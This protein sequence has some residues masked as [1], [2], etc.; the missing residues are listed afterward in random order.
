MTLFNLSYFSLLQIFCPCRF[1]HNT[2]QALS[3]WKRQ[4][5]ALFAGAATGLAL[6]PVNFFPICFLTFPILTWLLDGIYVQRITKRRQRYKAAILTGWNFGFGYFVAGLWWLGGAVLIDITVYGWIMPFAVF[7]LPAYLAFFYAFATFV[8]FLLW[9]PGYRRIITLSIAFGLAEWLRSQIFTGFPWNALGYTAMPFPLLIQA[10]AV[11]GLDGMNMLAVLVYTTP[12]LF[13]ER[14]GK[15]IGFLVAAILM[16]ADFSFGFYR[17]NMEAPVHILASK[18]IRV[19]II[20]PSILQSEKIDIAT[21]RV[22][23]ERHLQLTA[24]APINGVTPPRLIIWPETSVPYILDYTPAALERITR[25]LKDN[26]LALVG[27]VRVEKINSATATFRYFNSLQIIHP[28]GKIIASADKVHLVPFGEYLPL[29]SWFRKLGLQAIASFAGGYSAAEKHSII[30]LEN[31]L[32]LLPLICYEAIFPIDLT[33]EKLKPDVLVN[34]TNDAWFGNTPGPWQHFAQVRIRAVEQGISLI[35]AANNGIS[36]VT[37]PYGR[38]IAMLKHNEIGFID[39]DLPIKTVPVWS[40]NFTKIYIFY[41]FS[42]L[43]LSIKGMK[44]FVQDYYTG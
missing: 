14:K 25:I 22:N 9:K 37:D 19:R 36:A 27:A 20:Q 44:I 40:Q 30:A 33:H 12:A 16:I 2:I 15:K 1:A 4:I 5:I 17:L 7:G 10:V 43:L 38:I 18:T 23:F 8:A 41:I 6:P 42:L 11:I 24:A 28:K 32:L 35:R 26:Q 29:D 21:R 34:I 39:I 13:I 3:S 31:G